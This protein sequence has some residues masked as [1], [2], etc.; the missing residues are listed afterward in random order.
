MMLERNENKKETFTVHPKAAN[1]GQKTQKLS[2]ENV[3]HATIKDNQ[4]KASKSCFNEPNVNCNDLSTIET[5]KISN[6]YLKKILANEL[7]KAPE[8]FRSDFLMKHKFGS[9][10]RARMVR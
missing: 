4:L 10:I 2:K 1:S 3:L 5:N 7:L 6:D 8:N 9:E